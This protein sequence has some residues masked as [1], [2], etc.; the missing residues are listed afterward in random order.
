MEGLLLSERPVQ[1]IA[2][3]STSCQIPCHRNNTDCI[4]GL[5]HLALQGVKHKV[6]LIEEHDAGVE[7][8]QHL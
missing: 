4:D 5:P 2:S 8:G 1:L 6:D 3:E 7:E